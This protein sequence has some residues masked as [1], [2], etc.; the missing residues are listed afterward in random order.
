MSSKNI[1]M[2]GDHMQLPQPTAGNLDGESTYSP[3]EY[4]LKEKIQ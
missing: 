3:I 2:I 1:V 4:L